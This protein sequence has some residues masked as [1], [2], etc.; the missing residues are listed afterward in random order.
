MRAGSGA[1]PSASPI[2]TPCAARPGPGPSQ[3]VHATAPRP[4][5]TTITIAANAPRSPGTPW[6][7]ERRTPSSVTS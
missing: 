5:L 1:P 2:D 4:T 6:S 3:R 7:S